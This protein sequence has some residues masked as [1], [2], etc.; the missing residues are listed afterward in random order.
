MAA[1]PEQIKQRTDALYEGFLSDFQPLY[2]AVIELKRTMFKRIFGVGTSGGTTSEG[3][4][5]PSVPYSTKPI[6]VSAK[7][8]NAVT[9]K[10]Q[11]GK[12]REGKTKGKPI[13]SMYFPNGYAQLKKETPAKLPLE[14]TGRLK[15]GFQKQEVITEGLQAAVG[16]PESEAAKA[17][18]LQARYG[19]IFLPTGFE[20]D[21]MLE[22]HAQLLAQ[23]IINGLNT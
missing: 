13:K 8:V 5:L 11:F 15:G 23:S 4:K 1:T 22:E 7:S 21:V 20:Q 9:G 2:L 14:L 19:I 17:E 3:Q 10:F 18:G 16:V 6:Y 12:P